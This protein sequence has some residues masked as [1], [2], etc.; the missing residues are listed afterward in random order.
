M[1]LMK[2][3]TMGDRVVCWTDGV[4]A[5]MLVSLSVYL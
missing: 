4:M 1:V 2:V 5:M 3:V